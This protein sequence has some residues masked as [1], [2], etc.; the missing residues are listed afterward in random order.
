MTL[1]KIILYPLVPLYAVIV[2]IRNWLF[3]KGI[4]KSRKVDAKV[5]SIGNITVGGSGKTPTVIY[6]TNLL[7]NENRKIGVLSRG[8]GR[9]S[10]G[11]VLVA[12]NKNILTNAKSSKVFVHISCKR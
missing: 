1:L 3:D 12:D 8:Y 9:K 11:Y 2:N 6:L 7:K 5:I 4:F 10:S